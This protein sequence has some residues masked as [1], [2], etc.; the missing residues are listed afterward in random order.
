MAQ[1]ELRN[2]SLKQM[3]NLLQ[4]FNEPDIKVH[5]NRNVAVMKRVVP[6]LAQHISEQPFVMDEMRVMLVKNG[7]TCPVINLLPVEA[8]VGDLVFISK[9][10]TV[11][12]QDFSPDA[13]AE[14]VSMSDELFNLAMGGVVP[15]SLDGH[16]RD[17]KLHLEPEE[18][19]FTSQLITMLYDIIRTDDYSSH[20]FL[21]LAATFWWY[22]DALWTRR[23]D[24]GHR[25]QSREQRL[26]AKFISLVNEHARTE[27]NLEFYA[28]HLY[29]SPRYMG[30]M[31]K[32]QSGRSAKEWID[33]A[34][35]TAIKVELIY[36]QKALKQIANDL[37]FPN[38]SF[39]CKY[40][41]RMTGMTPGDYRSR[42]VERSADRPD[43]EWTKKET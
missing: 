34:I 21:S 17:F 38:T 27:H 13:Q 18:M 29:L 31:I 20:V 8:E 10:S 24:D 6:S 32:R 36:S 11:F 28:N 43:G 35:V 4:E 40:F 30:T 1:K 15:S 16:V 23:Q 26:F 22:V 3:Q 25:E 14:G 37:K 19:A 39:F 7:H 41:R 5:I 9:N 2:I 33:E 12:L 42:G